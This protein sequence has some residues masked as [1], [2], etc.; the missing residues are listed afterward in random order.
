MKAAVH[1]LTRTRIQCA[2]YH[3]HMMSAKYLTT[4]ANL[5]ERMRPQRER[6]SMAADLRAM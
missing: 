6:Q 4:Y 2:T 5:G 1:G 3:T